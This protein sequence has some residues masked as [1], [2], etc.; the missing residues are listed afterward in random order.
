ML[1]LC[2]CVEAGIWVSGGNW[3][4]AGQPRGEPG[5]PPGGAPHTVP[6]A[7][8][9]D[10][11][12]VLDW[13]PSLAASTTSTWS[14]PCA[15][16]V[17]ALPA[18]SPQAWTTISWF[19]LLQLGLGKLVES[20]FRHWKMSLSY[21]SALFQCFLDL[22]CH[23]LGSSLPLPGWM[24]LACTGPFL[25]GPCPSLAHVLPALSSPLD[26]VL[27]LLSIHSFSV[28]FSMSLF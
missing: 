4:G 1:R 23:T 2:V 3:T 15:P 5:R 8:L 27:S 26:L 16:W 10:G 28:G 7:Q 14:W 19:L 25:R 11:W 20:C 12:P 24:F 21:A 17:L 6:L 13:G 9:L 18:P 22:L